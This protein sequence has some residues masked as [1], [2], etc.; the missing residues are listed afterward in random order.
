MRGSSLLNRDFVIVCLCNFL[1][2]FS[3]YLIVP[4]LPHY[5]EGRGYSNTIIGALMSMMVVAAL[6]RPFLGNLSDTW[7]RRRILLAGTLVLALTNFLYAAFDAAMPLFLVRFF[8]GFGLAA[9]NTAAYAL[10]G[11]LA[12][13]ERRLQGIAIFFMSVDATIATAPPLAELVKSRW[14]Y[15][16]VYYLAGIVGLASFLL[17]ILS[18][19][20]ACGERRC[21]TSKGP[22]GSGMGVSGLPV[23]VA[24]CGF[25]MTIGALTTFVVLS[26]DK[27]GFGHGELFFVVFA[28]TLIVFRLAAGRWAERLP[29]LA[30]IV[31]SGLIAV[32]G[33]ATVAL[34]RSLVVFLLGSMVYALG[35]AYVPTTLS[36]LLLDLTAPERRGLVLGLFMAV[37]DIGVG[38]GGIVLGPLA[39]ALGY[40]SMYLVSACVALAGLGILFLLRKPKA[41]ETAGELR[42]R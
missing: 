12:P 28:V 30:L 2:F 15:D 9:F 10:V 11:D 6:S 4:V 35:I 26:S 34:A 38:L 1:S 19:E 41:E 17:A 20:T 7:G 39:D 21:T 8:N 36:A 32:I 31:A 27:A 5:L 16:A 22:E 40:P 37:F 14:G 24:T 23:Y 25:T 3:I 42:D 18:P 33:L 29:R 13:P